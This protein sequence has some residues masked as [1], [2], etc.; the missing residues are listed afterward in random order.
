MGTENTSSTLH[1]YLSYKRGFEL[2]SQKRLYLSNVDSY[3]DPFEFLPCSPFT[4]L[5]SKKDLKELKKELDLLINVNKENS[6]GKSLIPVSAMLATR[7]ALGFASMSLLLPIMTVVGFGSTLSNLSKEGRDKE[8]MILM[9]FLERYVEFLYRIGV[10]CFSEEDDN[11]LMWSHYADSHR[12]IVV[13][14]DPFVGY[15]G[16]N[17]FHRVSYSDER[18]KMITP[19]NLN[20]NG[21]VESLIT[22]KAKCWEYEKEWRYIKYEA[23][24]CP[25]IDV[26]IEG[27][28]V[29]KI[30][31]ETI[32]P[33]SIVAINLGFRASEEQCNE[34]LTY[35]DK[36]LKHVVVNL[37]YLDNNEFKLRFEKK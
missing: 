21:F 12:G 18:V 10:C 2:I 30:Y 27:S 26:P 5:L 37:A 3:N 11:I 36:H 33:E 23:Q 16:G 17:N 9:N 14:F 4:R 29:K 15:W 8:V 28:G 13:S 31:Y 20:A 24:K 19:S 6:L 32:K 25:S 1:R 22:T 35:R 7:L 34:I